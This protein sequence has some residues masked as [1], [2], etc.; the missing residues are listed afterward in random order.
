MEEVEREAVK[1]SRIATTPHTMALRKKR[2]RSAGEDGAVAGI[3]KVACVATAAA[4]MNSGNSGRR[5]GGTMPMFRMFRLRS[6]Q[7]TTLLVASVVIGS[8][9]ALSNADGHLPEADHR[10]EGR[11]RDA[12]L[13]VFIVV[14][15]RTGHTTAL[16]S[17]LARGVALRAPRTIA[18]IVEAGSP[19]SAWPAAAGAHAVAVGSPVHYGNPSARILQWLEEGLAPG[20]GNSTFEGVPASVFATGGG[21]HQGI[22]TVLASLANGLLNFGFQR[23]FRFRFARIENDSYTHS[24][25]RTVNACAHPIGPGSL[26]RAAC[27]RAHVCSAG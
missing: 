16:G 3:A 23:T 24:R 13:H 12:P 19:E 7:L 18:T 27:V 15:S 5:A 8:L 22:D 6:F 14:D 1:P 20:W 11:C 9:C 21:L 26:P 2:G 4:L 17:A 10:T 25:T